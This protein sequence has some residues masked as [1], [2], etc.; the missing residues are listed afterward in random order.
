M[1]DLE[2]ISYASWSENIALMYRNTVFKSQG[3]LAVSL[4]TT[5][6]AVL[7]VMNIA[8]GLSMHSSQHQ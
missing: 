6:A 5:M 3:L 1:S 4:Q 7:D 2:T 8:E